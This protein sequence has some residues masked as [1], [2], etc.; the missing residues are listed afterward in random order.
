[1]SKRRE[2]L[3]IAAIV[4]AVGGFLVFEVSQQIDTMTE[5]SK[6][7]QAARALQEADAK[8]K[9]FTGVADKAAALARGFTDS[10]LWAAERERIKREADAA[11]ER[12]RQQV[13]ETAAKAERQK[14]DERLQ[15]SACYDAER[16]VTAIL[17]AP[18]TAKF[19][20]CTD[21]R[22]SKDRKKV[23]VQGEVDAQNGFGAMLRNRYAVI[24]DHR[25]SGDAL[26]A[27]S[28]A[29]ATLVNR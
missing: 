28:G 14:Y 4:T 6:R 24:F 12:A 7:E 11:A 13:A 20:P 18:S 3:I 27:L 22:I 1:M 10:K 5:S 19:Q 15:F 23:Y 21:V 17:K 8:S 26:T 2:L 16:A 29:V 25:D 9:G